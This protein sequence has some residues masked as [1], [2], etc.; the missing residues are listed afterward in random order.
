[1]IRFRSLLPVFL[2]VACPTFA[3]N[4][5]LDSLDVAATSA[6]SVTD[7]MVGRFSGV[8]VSSI[9]G[10][11]NNKVMTNIR[12]INGVRGDN[13]PL[14]IVDGVMLSNN[15]GQN[16]GAFWQKG[17]VTTKGDELPDYSQLSYS[18]PLNDLIF[19]N[20]SEIES[21]EVIKDL[22]A[23]AKYGSLG[24][25]GVVIVNTGK[26]VRD[27]MAV[28]FKANVAGEFASSDN[29]A[30]RAGVSHNYT[31]SLGGSLRNTNYN[32]SAY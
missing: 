32:I 16:I 4:V 27:E 24:A 9:D 19:L 20:P 8:H 31:L 21:I 1:M 3:Q 26:D 6:R 12:G 7:L 28:S 29:P 25:N 30:A 13:Q 11:P 14:W 23:V 17:G 5:D 22:S 15:V 2:L 10:N 18:T